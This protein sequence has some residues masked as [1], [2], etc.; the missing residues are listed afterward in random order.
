LALG[1]PAPQLLKDASLAAQLQTT[2][3]GLLTILRNYNRR[4]RRHALLFNLFSRRIKLDAHIDST[5]LAEA[6]MAF[7]LGVRI[8]AVGALAVQNHDLLIPEQLLGMARFGQSDF[9]S[10]CATVPTRTDR[11]D[12]NSVLRRQIVAIHFHLPVR[13]QLPGVADDI[14]VAVSIDVAEA[15]T[16]IDRC[17]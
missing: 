1:A 11:S 9:G 5:T 7:G 4:I 8:V 6:K 12:M 2:D 16:V 3:H 14:Q 17:C 13:V 15:K 10:G